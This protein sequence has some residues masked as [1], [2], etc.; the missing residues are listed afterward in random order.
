MVAVK[1]GI[2]IGRNMAPDTP[3]DYVYQMVQ[4]FQVIFVPF[5]YHAFIRLCEEL[6]NPLGD[7]FGDF[8]GYAFH[9]HLRDNCQAMHEAAM[10]PPPALLV[11]TEKEEDSE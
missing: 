11:R 2:A 5:S 7:N 10:D 4:A 1:V 3:T 8:P 9:C 6:S